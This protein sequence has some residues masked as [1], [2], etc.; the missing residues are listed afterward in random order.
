MKVRARY[1]FAAETSDYVF[2]I[3]RNDGARSVTNDAEAV[4]E[5]MNKDFPGKRVIYRDTDGRWDELLHC[6][7][8]F[9]SFALYRGTIPPFAPRFP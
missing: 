7:G 9:I 3:D 1:D 6:N 5:E 2:I 8:K 4:V